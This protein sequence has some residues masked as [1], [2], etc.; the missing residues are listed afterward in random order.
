MLT[1]LACSTA[2]FAENLVPSGSVLYQDIFSNEQSG[3]GSFSGD[4]GTAGYL[5]GAYHIVVNQPQTNLWSHPGLSF[6]DVHLEVSSMTAAGP[7]SNRVGLICR[8]QNDQNYYFFVI[9]ADG[10][11][12][13]GKMKEGQASLLSGSAMQPHPAIQG[14]NQINRIHADCTG[15]TLMLF[16]NDTY[17]TSVKDADFGSGDVGI[18]A[19]TFDQ[20]GADVYFDNFLVLKP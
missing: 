1:A 20:P 8:L 16:V 17:I 18:L 4:A 13:I 14:G 12:G 19:G 2:G 6:S 9:S 5:N 3:W 11:Y 10:Y 15:D 7:L